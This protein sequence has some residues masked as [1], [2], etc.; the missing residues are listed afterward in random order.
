[1]GLLQGR[2]SK[3]QFECCTHDNYTWEYL[4]IIK[5]G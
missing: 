5:S 3:A 4:K 1:M 2:K